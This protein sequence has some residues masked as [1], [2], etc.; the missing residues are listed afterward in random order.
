[1]LRRYQGSGWDPIRTAVL[2]HLG[3]G[4]GGV[5]EDVVE[6]G[7][8][9]ERGQGGREGHVGHGAAVRGLSAGAQVSILVINEGFYY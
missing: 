6:G 5:P 4:L 2:A 8:W 9:A 1:M 3:R 7:Q